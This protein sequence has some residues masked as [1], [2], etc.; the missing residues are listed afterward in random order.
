MHS[1]EEAMSKKR[2]TAYPMEFHSALI[3]VVDG[4]WTYGYDG[5]I[6][7][8]QIQTIIMFMQNIYDA[9]F[10]LSTG[11]WIFERPLKKQATMQFTR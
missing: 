5:D 3:E 1:L 9:T 11:D 4:W 2:D 6:I 8:P 10:D 7:P